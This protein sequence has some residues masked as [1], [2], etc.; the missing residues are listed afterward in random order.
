MRRTTTI[1]WPGLA[2]PALLAGL[3]LL[4]GCGSSPTHNYYLLQAT[5]TASEAADPGISLGIGPV[6]VPEYLNRNAMVYSGPGN[7]LHVSRLDRWAEPLQDSIPRVLG[8]NLAAELGTQDL[9]PHPWQRS[10]FPDLAVQLWLLQLDVR[11]GDAELVAEWRLHRPRDDEELERRISRLSTPLPGGN[12]QP[13][14]AAAA[15]SELLQTLSGEIAAAARR[16]Q[17]ATD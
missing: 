2:I 16:A 12:W 1:S 14:A 6:T 9:R 4:A 8:L 5:S 13:D 17:P 7:R 10:Q 3:L 11:D 15:Y